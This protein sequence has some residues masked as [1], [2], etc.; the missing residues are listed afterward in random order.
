MAAMRRPSAYSGLADLTQSKLFQSS[1]NH[2]LVHLARVQLHRSTS[3]ADETLL[4]NDELIPTSPPLTDATQF[5]PKTWRKF[6]NFGLFYQSFLVGVFMSLGP[7]LAV[8]VSNVVSAR[9]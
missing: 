9:S 5:E 4:D 7:Q 8:H 1:I 6:A 3:G 2:G